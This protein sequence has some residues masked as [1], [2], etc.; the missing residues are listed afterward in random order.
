M[1]VHMQ[2]VTTFSWLKLSK[3][4]IKLKKG[5]FFYT[6]GSKECLTQHAN[7][8][9]EGSSIDGMMLY[10]GLLNTYSVTLFVQ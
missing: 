6:Q 10:G 1:D 3:I 5:F 7:Q 8:S 2:L 4:K 9:E